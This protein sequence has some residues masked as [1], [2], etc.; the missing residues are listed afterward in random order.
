M[1]TQ[2]W[3]LAALVGVGAWFLMTPK[4]KAMTSISAPSDN[5]PMGDKYSA[6]RALIAPIAKKYGVPLRVALAFAWLESRF[7]PK[8]EGDLEWYK[9]AN[10]KSAVTNNKKFAKN[11]YRTIPEVWHSYGLFQ[12][13]SPYY[14][15]ANESPKV[16]LEPTV[17]TDR[18]MKKIALS[19]K[20]AKGDVRQARI[21]YAGA[22]KSAD[23]VKHGILS[24]LDA[25]LA[26]FP[27]T[28]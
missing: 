25:A 3:L 6:I 16:L 14:T 22:S 20:T 26:L 7:N 15:N 18:A 11:P 4:A 13:L 2:P 8:A 17:N 12:L 9:G 19:L 23:S 24:K 1:K 27:T 28:L 10:F 5:S 21:I